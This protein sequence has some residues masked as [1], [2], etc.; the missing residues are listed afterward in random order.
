[1]KKCLIALVLSY[2]LLFSVTPEMLYAQPVQNPGNGHWY[3]V[4]TLATCMTWSEAR[5]YANT[6]SFN[7]M[8]G[9]LATVTSS[10]ENDFIEG[11]FFPFPGQTEV[12]VWIGGSQLPGQ[13]QTDLGWRWTTGEIWS[14]VDWRAGEPNDCCNPPGPPV[15]TGDEDCLEFNEDQ[16]D[17]VG[18]NDRNCGECISL[19][20]VE[21]EQA[22]A[23]VP[24]MGEW[25][26]VIF[27]VLG[28]IGAVYYLR[29]QMRAQG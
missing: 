27:T 10:Q 24:T 15:E 1:M 14:F 8:P 22:Q 7:G 29:R 2:L 21:F 25:G 17:V 16:V 6:L 3:E 4:I 13:P 23:A 20:L 11:T 28:G 26:V 18:W 12:R 5:N 19:I 9:H